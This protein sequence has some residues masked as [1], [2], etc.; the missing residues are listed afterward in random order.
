MAYPHP[1]P[2]LTAAQLVAALS[3]VS[4]RSKDVASCQA[5]QVFSVVSLL[6]LAASEIPNKLVKP[7]EM[8]LQGRLVDVVRRQHP[9]VTELM[10]N[11]AAVV[12]SNSI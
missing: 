9:V 6:Q 5:V 7:T 8:W 1:P 11:R 2:L 3:E 12:A 4:K 10:P